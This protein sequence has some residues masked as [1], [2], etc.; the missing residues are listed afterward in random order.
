MK[1]IFIS[2]LILFHVSLNLYSQDSEYS[3]FTFENFESEV[4]EY[5]PLQRPGVSDTD[6]S[7]GK[8]VLSQTKIAV[9]N[10]VENFNTADYW[11][12][13]FA[14]RKLQE[15][16][17]SWVIAFRKMAESGKGCDYLKEFRD[18]AGFYEEI[19]PLYD[20]YLIN[21]DV[22]KDS[23]FDLETYCNEH[24]LDLKLIQLI[25]LIRSNDQKFRSENIDEFELRQKELDSQNLKGIDSLYKKHKRYLGSSLVGPQFKNVMWLV[26]QH[27]NVK[28]MELYLPVIGNAVAA[29][30][31][32]SSP[33]KMLI[34]RIYSSK[35][36]Y[37]IY[38]TQMG[39]PIAN[40]SI[41]QTVIEKFNLE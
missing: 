27:S 41:R 7:T 9:K 32:E 1:T 39:V 4:L 14:F 12:I 37:Q 16:K 2:I 38:G 6:Y 29:G 26:I 8:V 22:I 20:Q 28:T 15:D 13:I 19:K 31:L 40:D 36:D 11:N 5:D 3:G 33:L 25:D 17:N 35:Y 21:C 24:K 10:K 23:N 30:E 34:D 18:L